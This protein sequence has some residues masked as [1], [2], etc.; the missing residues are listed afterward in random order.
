MSTKNMAEQGWTL[1]R[2]ATYAWTKA[3]PKHCMT[4]ALWILKAQNQGEEM[5][6]NYKQPI[7]LLLNQNKVPNSIK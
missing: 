1:P 5:Q 4:T 2:K 6:D 7:K 3:L